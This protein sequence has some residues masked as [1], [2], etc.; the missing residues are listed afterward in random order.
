MTERMFRKKRGVDLYLAGQGRVREGEI[1]TGDAYAGFCPDALE[2][3]LVEPAPVPV[4]PRP[5]PRA[6][7]PAPKKEEVRT[8]ELLTEDLPE[9][10]EP[11]KPATRKKT[12][13]RKKKVEDVTE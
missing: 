6:P 3:I 2:E 5:V 13:R 10:P 4:T 9:A 7:K 1:L 8:M 12:T 11:K